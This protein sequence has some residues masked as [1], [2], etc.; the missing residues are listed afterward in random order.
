M[1][2]VNFKEPLELIKVLSR[3]QAFFQLPGFVTCVLR[4]KNQTRNECHTSV[5]SPFLLANK[6]MAVVVVHQLYT[7]QKL[8]PFFHHSLFSWRLEFFQFSISFHASTTSE[9]AMFP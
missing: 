7:H 3:G 8:F 6:T 9:F 4:E 2:C 5:T 1:F